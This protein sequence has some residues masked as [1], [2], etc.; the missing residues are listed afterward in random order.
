MS[1]EKDHSWGDVFIVT[2]LTEKHDSIMAKEGT[3]E[4]E[5]FIGVYVSETLGGGVLVAS[6]PSPSPVQCAIGWGSH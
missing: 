4:V 1:G 2:R 6:P 3:R 5:R